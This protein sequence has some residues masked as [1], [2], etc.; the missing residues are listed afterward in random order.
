MRPSGHLRSA[1]S[2]ITVDTHRQMRAK[3][4]EHDYYKLDERWHQFQADFAGTVGFVPVEAQ[5]VIN[6]DIMFLFEYGYR[7]DSQ[8]GEPQT[9]FGFTS[10]SAPPGTVPYAHVESWIQ[11]ADF[12]YIGAN[13]IVGVHNPMIGIMGTDPTTS[14]N[15]SGTLHASFQ[16]YGVP[17]DPDDG[18]D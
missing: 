3:A 2:K 8:L 12:N 18:E 13:V 5:L 17:L 7:R 11:D 4:V 14:L 15:F 9:H 1:V 6:F 16:G 10:L